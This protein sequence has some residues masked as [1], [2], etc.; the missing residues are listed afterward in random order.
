MAPG[1]TLDSVL[2]EENIEEN[3]CAFGLDKDYLTHKIHKTK[4]T[5]DKLCLIKF[6][7]FLFFKDIR[8]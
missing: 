2:L 5:I 3:L 1:C 7:K 6:L 4:E 8:K